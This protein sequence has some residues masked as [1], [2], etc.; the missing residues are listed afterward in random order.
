[1]P[2]R[3]TLKPLYNYMDD[4]PGIE[5]T[6]IPLMAAGRAQRTV[7]GTDQFRRR[8]RLSL[9]VLVLHHHQRARPEI[10]P[11]L[12]GRHRKDRAGELRA[13]AALLLHHRRQFRPQQGLGADPRP[14]HLSARNRKVQTGLHHP[15]R[16]ALSQA[17]EFHRQMRARRREAGLHRPGK[18]QSGQ[19][20]RRQEAAKQDHR[21]PHDAARVESPRA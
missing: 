6:P 14:A 4:L 10:A 17:A 20:G 11:P 12:A 8:P 13:R 18:Y 9:P 1:M 21:I 16:H 19:S 3:G 5:G 15:G 7:G 2:P